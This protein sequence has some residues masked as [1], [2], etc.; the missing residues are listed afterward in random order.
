M[1]E[2]SAHGSEK[3]RNAIL[4]EARAQSE[5]IVSKARDTANRLVATAENEA[6]A[7]ADQKLTAARAEAS[8]R[9]E[10]ILSTVSL[11]TNRL[12]LG[13]VEACLN[14]VYDR[15]L[16]RVR[17]GDGFDRHAALVH[18]AVEALTRMNGN[19]FLLRLSSADLSALGDGLLEA[20]RR[21][22]T[23]PWLKLD[24]GDDPEA[25]DG[26]WILQDEE[27][28]QM[29]YLG[30]EARLD[31]VWPDLRRQIAAQAGFVDSEESPPR[32]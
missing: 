19:G 2:A 25:R 27:G 22:W 14:S 12:R 15:A 1:N 13:Q 5:A 9:Q 23:R 11:E 20:I 29:W 6:N 16:D 24:V 10:A 28:R 3:L 21:R 4:A 26:D 30:L 31:R 32:A 17:R 7:A 18:L 8:R